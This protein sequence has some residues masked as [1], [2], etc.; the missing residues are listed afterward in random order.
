MR[1]PLAPYRF[2]HQST[3]STESFC[4]L[5][6]LEGAEPD[7]VPIA[8]MTDADIVCSRAKHHY[9]P[10]DGLDLSGESDTATSTDKTAIL[11]R[12]RAAFKPL[13]ANQGRV[14]YFC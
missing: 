13:H 6:T 8:T 14:M 12:F 4:V 10:E 5:H 11:E 1:V 3:V 2:P 9:D 7:A